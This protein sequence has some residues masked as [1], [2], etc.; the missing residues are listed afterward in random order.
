MPSQQVARLL[1]CKAGH[2]ARVRSGEPG[3]RRPIR[4]VGRRSHQVR[5][6]GAAPSFEL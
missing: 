6:H 1:C 3:L 4:L 2:D 5:T